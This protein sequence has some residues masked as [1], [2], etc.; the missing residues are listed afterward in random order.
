MRLVVMLALIAAG[1]GS[2]QRVDPVARGDEKVICVTPHPSVRQTFLNAYQS[3][4]ERKGF[5]VLIVPEGASRAGCQLVSSY[6]ARWE[7]VGV[8]MSM[9]HADLRVIRDGV[10]AGRAIYNGRSMISAEEKI[11]ELVDRL[12]PAS[13]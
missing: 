9:T 4:L 5:T 12:F 3:A 2:T 1:C 13:R 11:I 6:V 8:T 7:F 10:L